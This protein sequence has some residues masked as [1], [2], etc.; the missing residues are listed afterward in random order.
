MK[1]VVVLRR[2]GEGVNKSMILGQR[3]RMKGVRVIT[4]TAL[5]R[6]MSVRDGF[7]QTEVKDR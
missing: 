1:G 3:P 6:C 5:G 7:F 4:L 2:V